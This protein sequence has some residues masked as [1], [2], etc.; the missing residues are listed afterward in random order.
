MK[1][2]ILSIVVILVSLLSFSQTYYQ[3]LKIMGGEDH[4]VFLGYLNKSPVDSESIWNKNGTYGNK[5][6]SNC[7]W[8]KYGTYGNKH[9]SLSPWNKYSNSCPVLVDSYDR[10]YGLFNEYNRDK[11]VQNI[12]KMAE[13]IM[14]GDLELEDAYKILFDQ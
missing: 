10:S 3:P 7:I 11:L 9:S 14:N 12:C 2:Y 1:K 4:D 5:Y 8:N 6:N 13:A